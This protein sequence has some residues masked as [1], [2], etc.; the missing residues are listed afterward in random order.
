MCRKK[1]KTLNLSL[2]YTYKYI[3]MIE[4][5]K[6]KELDTI[7]DTKTNQFEIFLN[8]IYLWSFNLIHKLIA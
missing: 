4:I 8:F 6:K 5:K 2:K 1:N 7:S 3:H